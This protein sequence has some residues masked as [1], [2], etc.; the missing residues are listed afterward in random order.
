MVVRA[1]YRNLLAIRKAQNVLENETYAL[2]LLGKSRL[3]D[4]DYDTVFF[5]SIYVTL[6]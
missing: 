5:S 1:T 4:I 3:I 2:M 6:E